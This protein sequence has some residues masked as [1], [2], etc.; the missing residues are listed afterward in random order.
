MRREVNTIENIALGITITQRQPGRKG[1]MSR[2]SQVLICCH[3]FLLPDELSLCYNS[4]W[5]CRVNATHQYLTHSVGLNMHNGFTPNPILYTISA[6]III[7]QSGINTGI[8]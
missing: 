7:E 4:S 2:S 5:Y 1:I 8:P 6:E 3:L